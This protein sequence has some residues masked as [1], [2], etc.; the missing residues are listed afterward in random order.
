[1]LANI[2][3]KI[4]IPLCFD[5]ILETLSW[6]IILML[7][8][9]NG[10][11][12]QSSQKTELDTLLQEPACSGRPFTVIELPFKNYLFIFLKNYKS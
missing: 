2:L 10:T 12:K 8:K 6:S 9:L 3:A 1:M 7:N 5:E 11:P 4:G